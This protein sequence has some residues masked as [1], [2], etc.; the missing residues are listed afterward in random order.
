VRH[1][2]EESE[3]KDAR[4]RE[5]EEA[6]EKAL[7][8]YEELLSMKHERELEML[9]AWRYPPTAVDAVAEKLGRKPESDG[10]TAAKVYAHFLKPGFRG[11][12][13]EFARIVHETEQSPRVVR[14][15]W[16]QF[17]M[18]SGV[19]TEEQAEARELDRLAREY[20]EQI[21]AMDYAL[22]RKRRRLPRWGGR[23][24]R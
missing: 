7:A 17:K 13:E 1:Y 14:E 9:R 10:R 5:L 11:T 24:W 8:M 23:C 18:G 3:R 4:I 15:L 21:A 12:P 6:R 16:M 2:K 20:D 19:P 22:T